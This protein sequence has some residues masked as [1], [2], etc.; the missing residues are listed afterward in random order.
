MLARTQLA[1]EGKCDRAGSGNGWSIFS[2]PIL[3]PLELQAE[4]RYPS[5]S[6]PRLKSNLP[7]NFGKIYGEKA[8]AD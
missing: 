7:V 5:P 6:W 8:A 4:M 3:A 2:H 1:P